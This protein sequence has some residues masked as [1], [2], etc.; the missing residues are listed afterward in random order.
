VDETSKVPEAQGA[1]IKEHAIAS[2]M[3]PDVMALVTITKFSRIP[4][5]HPQNHA[6][7]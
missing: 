7:V 5:S 4:N 3:E 6:I 1:F 2:G